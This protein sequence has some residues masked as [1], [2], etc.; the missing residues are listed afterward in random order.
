MP[1]WRQQP[2]QKK[3][4]DAAD[5]LRE[6]DARRTAELAACVTEIRDSQGPE[7]VT[8]RLVAE[9]VGVP[10]QFVHWKYPAIE[11]LL[12]MAATFAEEGGG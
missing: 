7:V 4:R 1:H 8:H 5:I 11:T 9:R 2:R 10:V 6:R 12:A 3:R